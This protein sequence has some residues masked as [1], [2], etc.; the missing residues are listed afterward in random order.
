MPSPSWENLDDF[1]DLDD[2]AVPVTV[3]FQDG[4]TRTVTVLFNN[5]YLGARGAD[6]V[7]DNEAPHIRGKDAD[8]AGIV[9]YDR[10]TYDGHVYDVLSAPQ[11]DGYGLSRLP[12]ALA[13]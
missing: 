1:L 3:E 13:P 6:Y 7:S 12:L 9:R 11:S 8:L 2:F 4:T 5:P 10:V